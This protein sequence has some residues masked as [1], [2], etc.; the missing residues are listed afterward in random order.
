MNLLIGPN[1]LFAEASKEI[2][3]FHSDRIIIKFKENSQIL[4]YVRNSVPRFTPYKIKRSDDSIIGTPLFS[5]LSSNEINSL[6]PV[7]WDA[8]YNKL[9]GGVE[10]IF[11]AE[12]NQKTNVDRV[13]QSLSQMDEIEYVE[14]D[15]IGNGDG[16]EI[17]MQISDRINQMAVSMSDPN[18]PEFSQQWGLRN[19]GQTIGNVAG[20]T[21]ADINILP[22]WDITTGSDEIILAILDSGMPQDASEFSGRLLEGY[23]FVNDDNDPTDDHGHGTNVISIAAATGNNGI[24]IAGIDWKC[25]ILPLKILDENNNGLYSW[26]VEALIFATDNNAKIIN[27]S[28]GGSSESSSLRDA[29]T[30]ASSKDVI[31]VASMMNT[32]SEDTFYPAAYEDVI[33]VG[34]T[35]NLDQRA[36]PFCW[37]GGSNLGNHID[38]VAPGNWIL[39][40]SHTNPEETSFWCGTSQ[41]TPMVTG[42]IS[43]LLSINEKLTHQQIIEAVKQSAKDQI[44]SANEDVQGW[45]KYYG[46]GRIDAQ[47][48]LNH[49][50]TTQPTFKLPY[51]T[52]I[53]YRCT[54]GPGGSFSHTDSF[55]KYDLD[56]D[57]PNDKDEIV[58]AAT[59]G[60]AYTHSDGGPNSF[61][62]HINIDHGNSFFTVYAH[63]K[64]FLISNGEHV[65]QGQPI[66]IEGTTG[67]ST[68][69]HIHFGLHT[70]DPKKDAINS[71][72]ILIGQ[73]EARDVT[74]G[75][76]FQ[77]LRGDEFIA[78][79]TDGHF[80]ESNNS[81][82]FEQQIAVTEK[83]WDDIQSI[84]DGLEYSYTNITNPQLANPNFDLSQYDIIFINC[85]PNAD[86]NAPGAAN[87]LKA[88]VS[89]GGQLYASDYAYSYIK[90]AFPGYLTFPANPK[91]GNAQTVQ[92]E[93]TDPGLASVIGNNT[94]NLN[95]N[96]PSWVVID[97][98]STEVTT[99]LFGT[100]ATSTVAPAASSNN[101]T[102]TN[103]ELHQHRDQVT[104]QGIAEIQSGPLMVS[105]PYGNGNVVFTT[106]HNEAQQSEAEKKLLNYLVLR[107]ATS[108]LLQEAKNSLSAGFQTGNEIIDVINQGASQN[109]L[110][111]NNLSNELEVILN[112]QTG[113][114]KLDL[115]DPDGN[116]NASKQSS[117]PP[118]KASIPSANFGPWE[119][120]VTALNIPGNNYPFVIVTGYLPFIP[121]ITDV[122]PKTGQQGD[123]LDITITGSNFIPGA[124][125]SFS[126]QGV[127]VNSTNVE[128]AS[129]ITCNLSIE[130]NADTG[131]RNVIISNPNGWSGIGT[132][133]FTVEAC[134]GTFSLLDNFEDGNA[135]GWQPNIPS[136]W[137]VQN[138]GGDLAYCLIQP[139]P[140]GNEYALWP[141]IIKDFTL[142]LDAKC[143]GTTNKGYIVFWGAVDFTDS[144][145]DS[146]VLRVLPSG[147]DLFQSIAGNGVIIG[148][149]AGDFVSDN[150]Y[151]HV[152]V[153]H[154]FPNIKVTIDGQF[155]F[156]VNDNTY[157][158]GYIGYG[159]RKNTGCFDNISI[160]ASG[161]CIIAQTAAVSI[162]SGL[163]ISSGGLLT[164]PVKVSTQKNIGLA[165]FTIEY[166]DN[167]LQFD[168]AVVGPDAAN[169]SISQ[170]STNPPFPPK[171]PGT[172]RN[173]I[174]Q[175]SSGGTNSFTGNNLTVLNLDFTAVG[176][177]GDSTPLAIDTDCQHTFLTSIELEDICGDQITFTNGDA[178]IKTSP[179][180]TGH[181]LYYA[182]SKP[183]SSVTLSLAGPTVFSDVTDQ[184]GFYEFTNVTSDNYT[185]TPAK[186]DDQRDA[187][188]G[189]DALLLMRYLAF[190]ES[191]SVDQLVCADVSGNGAVTGAD[192][193]AILRY[194]AFFTTQIGKTGQ[195][196]FIPPSVNLNIT[197]DIVQN[198]KGYLLGDVTGNWGATPI[199][200][201]TAKMSGGAS[202]FSAKIWFGPITEESNS[203]ITLP[204]FVATDS[205]I[206]LAQFIV[207]FDSTVIQPLTPPATLGQSVSTFSIG[208]FNTNLPFSP[209]AVGTNKNLL[210]QISGGGNNT[211]SGDSV[212]VLRLHFEVRGDIGS[213]TPLHFD[214]AQGRTFLTTEN[215][216]DLEG[217][218][219][220]FQN[221][222][223][224]VPVEEQAQQ[225]VPT[226][227]SLSHNYPN[228][229]NPV[230]TIEY[231]LP[232]R[233]RVS[234]TIYNLMGQE[235]ITLVNEEK[236]AGHFK[237][238]WDGKD[239]FGNPVA[240]GIYVFQMRTNR[241]FVQSRK[242]VLVR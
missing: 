202:Q 238:I 196:S 193:V 100:Y 22:A 41:A 107:P 26:W 151:H 214:Q 6:R 173:L 49:I 228:P 165:Q 114:F 205:I 188:K 97:N 161:D 148:S 23:D 224:V 208:N 132:A 242:L 9:P 232:E 36:V 191:L 59:D 64:S 65:V 77:I 169:F 86:A 206:S 180:L 240:S 195:W 5:F 45:D 12:L 129:K 47:A 11:V 216:N 93:I 82:S 99:Y 150:N 118:I 54:Q 146:Y 104:N 159:V 73:I 80:Y 210:V 186:S 16:V 135:A 153:E 131:V 40:L 42:V 225:L 226:E 43:L 51:P 66:G 37:G 120:D 142:E 155:L 83:Y 109:Y 168:K 184:N 46:W 144:P 137:Q 138:D 239:S 128:S 231:Q 8:N 187:I 2:K 78:G 192:A 38:F 218:S 113:E 203:N 18:D 25:K 106:F 98:V 213:R 230:T 154:K 185:L 29:V 179:K 91:I 75:A 182:D 200:N 119:Y 124:T 116:L 221:G 215:L 140:D 171:T 7:K 126:G 95:Y 115:Y 70:G 237:T 157:S 152:K 167:T 21:G 236:D 57:T 141:Q 96:L 89:N 164:V 149:A 15:Y 79:L 189:S 28:A 111:P 17:K 162:P 174:I 81:Q 234:L 160:Q 163:E 52:G 122:S 235:I 172:N 198:F 199:S 204:I 1:M 166:N 143:T 53:V 125:V 101:L 71:T 90:E 112:W 222:D 69:D 4:A 92:A 39:G 84:L 103:E 201:E 10:R 55:T 74:L 31:V 223:F 181:V 19:T 170:Q 61:G 233:A 24:G 209:T 27:I 44:G 50:L 102:T 56:F 241:D 30:Y 217:E 123:I 207:E 178:T 62:N 190:L 134:T 85:S 175:I 177:L 197:S 63:L 227:F 88:W 212:E 158:Q 130:S 32:N 20:K 183:V 72:S 33:A 60:I 68:G 13:R 34:A 133:L 156:E 3:E 87:R 35:N 48:A 121:V 229:F 211:F 219:I 194:L 147:V 58:V 145:D 67:F 110:V 117:T 108:Q 105:F 220:D 176:N 139:N 127:L 94:I 14:P 76:D 136:R